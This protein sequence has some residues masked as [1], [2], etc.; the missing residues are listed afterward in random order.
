[1]GR[2]GPKEARQK[3]RKEAK[4]K[5]THIPSTP[6]APGHPVRVSLI[7]DPSL[8]VLP[9]S[10]PLLFYFLASPVAS[11]Q[12]GSPDPCLRFMWFFC[13]SNLA[14][15]G[16]ADFLLSHLHLSGPMTPLP[17]PL[18]PP[19][20]SLWAPGG[21]TSRRRGW[22][23]GQLGG[24]RERGGGW[25]SC[26]G[27]LRGSICHPGCP[28]NYSAAVRT[29]SLPVCRLLLKPACCL[30]LSKPS[31]PLSWELQPLSGAS[32]L[33]MFFSGYL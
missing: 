21:P 4:T 28:V 19:S 30:L 10:V 2:G 16:R 22:F 8:S 27:G 9:A 33:R 29:D 3:P 24:M 32:I 7:S 31:L 17:C 11:E 1:M 5:Q 26:W 15:M 25:Y 14:V 20:P 6:L 13:P 12:G 18:C 23:P